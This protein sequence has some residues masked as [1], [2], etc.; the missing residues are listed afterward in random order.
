M[1]MMELAT[2]TITADSRMG[3]H[4][5]VNGTMVSSMWA[6][7]Y[8]YGSASVVI[9]SG[10]AGPDPACPLQSVARS[11]ASGRSSRAR[12]GADREPPGRDR[13][14]EPPSFGRPGISASWLGE[15]VRRFRQAEAR[16][17]RGR[18]PTQKVLAPRPCA[19]SP[20]NVREGPGPGHRLR[21]A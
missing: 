3:S 19:P 7:V 9:Q 4:S 14:M 1:W 21:L 18:G 20:C 17:V 13:R 11:S 16:D 10:P 15:F 5:E 2:K 6:V 8:A 12:K